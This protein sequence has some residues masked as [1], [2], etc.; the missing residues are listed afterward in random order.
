MTYPHKL[1]ERWHASRRWTIE[2][3]PLPFLTNAHEL[4]LA[5][6]LTV[7]GVA[8]LVQEARPGSVVSSVPD[9]MVWTWSA[10]IL[11]GGVATWLGVFGKRQRT[12]WVGQIMA[13]H[14]CG[15]YALAVGTHAEPKD[16]LVVVLVFTM[17][18]VVSHWRAFKIIMAPYVQARL[19]REATFA[20]LQAR[21]RGGQTNA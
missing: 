18:S 5:A 4:A 6:A 13:G 16:S 17:L 10:A 15:F 11:V 1:A 2:H 21:S 9:W 14:G 19:A 3:V 12:E 8:L 20:A 7:L